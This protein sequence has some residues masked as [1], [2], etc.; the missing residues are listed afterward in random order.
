MEPFT[1]FVQAYVIIPLSSLNFQSPKM[2]NHH[3][4]YPEHDPNFTS[5]QQD[6]L[7]RR[8]TTQ[9]KDGLEFTDGSAKLVSIRDGPTSVAALML[10]ESLAEKIQN[11]LCIAHQYWSFAESI[12]EEIKT[13][14][15]KEAETQSCEDELEHIIEL[16][17]RKVKR[18]EGQ[19]MT[20]GTSS[21]SFWKNG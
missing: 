5:T 19:Q 2:D 21:K 7:Y 20:R 18:D 1:S 13:R 3:L 11:A 6:L 14:F 8:W 4:F 12:P 15:E 9:V 17:K 10:S 16:T